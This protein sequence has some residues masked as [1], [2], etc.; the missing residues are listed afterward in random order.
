[1]ANCASCGSTRWYRKR[2]V[3]FDVQ[4]GG[5]NIT[6]SRSAAER[7]LRCTLDIC[8]G[9]GRTTTYVED[10]NEWLGVTGVDEV[11]ETADG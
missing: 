3:V 6:M 2:H 4:F 9:C 8:A 11:I 10:W 7:R 5:G 1:M